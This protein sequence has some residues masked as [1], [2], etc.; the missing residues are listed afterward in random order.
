MCRALSVILGSLGVY[1][2]I[3]FDR[4]LTSR[5]IEIQDE[6]PDR[7]LPAELKAA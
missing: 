4:K 1:L 3:Q 2:A 6:R 7:M 5:A